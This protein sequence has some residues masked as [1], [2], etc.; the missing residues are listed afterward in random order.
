MKKI[1]RIIAAV[2]ILCTF[3]CLFS[4]C[5]STLKGTYKSESLGYTLTF[6]KDNKVTG[7]LF[8]IT[9]DGTYEIKDGNI[10]LSYKSPIG[11][12]ATITKPFEK[13]GSTI[14]IDDAV[15]EK[16]S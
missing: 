8:G 6:D 5:G 14:K 2:L 13:D 9:I 11:V 4:S 12:G 1:T 10:T 3:V 16:V 15:L 7:E